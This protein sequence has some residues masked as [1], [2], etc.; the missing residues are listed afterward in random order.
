M[1]S[2]SSV[3]SA[4]VS[5]PMDDER[6]RLKQFQTGGGAPGPQAMQG[7][8]GFASSLGGWG[9]GSGF[10]AQ[11]I[12]GGGS[13]GGGSV[14]GGA[15]PSGPSG[16]GIGGNDS[17][18]TG[19]G[20]VGGGGEVGGGGAVGGGGSIPGA[21]GAFSMQSGD[22]FDLF[23]GSVISGA[24][25]FPADSGLST[26]DFQ[27]SSDGNG[28]VSIS[29]GNG[30]G[31]SNQISVQQGTS[32]GDVT[33]A[34][35]ASYGNG[36]PQSIGPGGTA[37]IDFG[38]FSNYAV[39]NVRQEADGSISFDVK[40]I[41]AA[42]QAPSAQAEPVGSDPALEAMNVDAPT[43]EQTAIADS[44]PDASPEAQAAASQMMAAQ[45]ATA[46]YAATWRA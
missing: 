43:P 20:S 2:I 24:G 3:S 45:M 17:G 13:I 26:G 27:L 1:T 14:G 32:F 30:G 42:A 46:A 28:G 37:I 7:N 15:S 23:T 36:G 35:G 16:G 34:D 29:L 11:V 8:S 39:G 44:S 33:S 22:G 12:G 10:A 5:S 40:Q 41:D 9:G 38:G 31:F 4:P 6:Q 25:S 21:S 18:G 19:G